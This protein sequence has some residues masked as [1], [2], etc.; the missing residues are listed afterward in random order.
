[1]L[2]EVDTLMRKRKINTILCIGDSTL[3]N[4]ELTYLV[5]TS[6]PRGGIY[7]KKIGE[8]PILVVGNID[9]GNA[10]RGIV[11]NI[12]TFSDYN[13]RDLL[14]RYGRK[15]AYIELIAAILKRN[16]AKERIGIYGKVESAKLL[17]LVDALRRKGFKITGENKP[18]IL[19]VMRRRKDSWEIEA[20]RE[21]AGK[22]I[23]IVQ[24][25]EKF[26]SDLDVR[27]GVA[28]LDGKKITVGYVKNL[29]RKLC[30]ENELQ[31]PE[32]HIFAVGRSSS[33]PH[34]AGHEDDLIT[35]GE[36]IVFDIFP[37]SIKT[38][39]WYD[40]T[41]TYVLGRPSPMLSRIYEDV[42]EAQ[43]IAIDSIHAGMPAGEVMDIVCQF[44]KKNG[45]PTILDGSEYEG[46]IHSLGHGVGLTIGEEPYLTIGE[47]ELLEKNMVVT[48]EPGLYYPEI[49]GVR[50]EDVVIVEETKSTVVKEHRPKLEI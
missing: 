40:F 6:L 10:R 35:E 29:V 17:Y 36:P 5:R 37:Q 22:T 30:V 13:Y 32:D 44:F 24:K 12:Q 23:K 34:E 15:R 3:G 9:V 38:G 16:K 43:A 28:A 46:F 7:L 8:E 25:V 42:A 1:M 31:L 18:T 41:R 4:P 11:K 20:I 49:G 2:E 21:V 26:L 48:V 45:R 19:D 47:E 33:D 14:K 39:Y 27:D 50:I